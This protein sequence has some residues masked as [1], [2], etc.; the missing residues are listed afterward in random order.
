MGASMDG[1]SVVCL[2]MFCGLCDRLSGEQKKLNNFF[3]V[4]WLK[5]VKHDQVFSITGIICLIMLNNY[6][7]EMFVFTYLLCFQS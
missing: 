5:P 1:I 3:W 4:K 2:Y 6:A 7:A